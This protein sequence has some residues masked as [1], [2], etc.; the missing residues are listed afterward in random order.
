MQVSAKELINI[1][2]LKLYSAMQGEDESHEAKWL[3]DLRRT[4]EAC[5]ARSHAGFSGARCT[6]R[7]AIRSCQRF[8]GFVAVLRHHPECFS[9]HSL[10]LP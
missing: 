5:G 10:S 8:Q 1:C 9:L 2:F 4:V 7:A 6:V 3:A